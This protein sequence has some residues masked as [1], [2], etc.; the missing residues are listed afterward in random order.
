MAI[1]KK[2]KNLETFES[3]IRNSKW[4]PFFQDGGYICRFRDI[5]VYILTQLS[6]YLDLNANLYKTNSKSSNL[7]PIFQNGGHFLKMA[8]IDII[9][10]IL[11]CIILSQ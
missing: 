9:I 8:A 7:T 10:A 4:R 11:A 5:G 1:Y 3:D 2:K 6:D